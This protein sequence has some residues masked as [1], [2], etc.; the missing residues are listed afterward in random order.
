MKG[1]GLCTLEVTHCFRPVD[2]WKRSRD[3]LLGVNISCYSRDVVSESALVETMRK[4]VPTDRV[5]QFAD[6]MEA[7]AK[8]TCN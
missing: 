2:D 6:F 5:Y 3:K 8:G 4:H 7:E 1:R